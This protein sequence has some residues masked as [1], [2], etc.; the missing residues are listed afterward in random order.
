M[1]IVQKCI[2]KN[3]LALYEKSDSHL[4]VNAW[5]Y[6]KSY[7][8]DCSVNEAIDSFY[9]LTS[10]AKNTP[11]RLITLDGATSIT[12]AAINTTDA[13]IFRKYSIFAI[14]FNDSQQLLDKQ[15]TDCLGVAVPE[16]GGT[17]VGHARNI[18][19]DV[20]ATVN[21][22]ASSLNQ[23]VSSHKITKRF[24]SNGR[25]GGA[26]LITSATNGILSN[27]DV[28]ITYSEDTGSFDLLVSHKYLVYPS[29][30]NK[31]CSLSK[32]PD[33]YSSHDSLYEALTTLRRICKIATDEEAAFLAA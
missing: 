13:S 21:K 7:L 11:Y 5:D 19:N 1:F 10:R 32:Q 12:L 29:Y 2:K 9:K 31:I 27:S 25:S 23:L 16:S 20:K 15:L 6:K 26:F 24:N 33:H 4:W 28:G 22:V 8:K 18:Q 3:V 14:V 17:V 30:E